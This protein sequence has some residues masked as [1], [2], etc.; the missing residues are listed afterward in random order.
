MTGPMDLIGKTVRW[1]QADRPGEWLTALV[2]R[3]SYSTQDAVRGECIDP[4]TFAS[5]IKPGEVLTLQ[6]E[7]CTVIDSEPVTEDKERE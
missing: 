5:H 1:E 7:A 4:G 3:R 2:I 6:R